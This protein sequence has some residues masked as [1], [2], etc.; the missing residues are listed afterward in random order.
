MFGKMKRLWENVLNW[1][2]CRCEETLRP[3][4][5]KLRP[6]QLPET[7]SQCQVTYSFVITT[8]CEE[9]VQ[10]ILDRLE[11][12][13]LFFCFGAKLELESHIVLGMPSRTHM[14]RIH[15]PN[16]GQAIEMKKQL[17]LMN[18]EE[19]LMWP[20][21]SDGWINIQF[22]WKQREVLP[23]YLRRQSSSPRISPPPP[24]TPT[25]TQ[26]PSSPWTEELR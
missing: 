17:S 2:N 23:R 25:W 8:P 11:L 3:T 10:T 22:R 26:R 20:T 5:M 12:I 16:G 6:L 1:G 4:G 14:L 9:S 15:A 21:F 19:V 24:G 18:F 13:N 7:S